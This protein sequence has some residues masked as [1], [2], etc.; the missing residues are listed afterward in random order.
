M[1]RVEGFGSGSFRDGIQGVAVEEMGLDKTAYS[2]MLDTSML[3]L[4][5]D[6]RSK[7]VYVKDLTYADELLEVVYTIKY[8]FEKELTM[9]SIATALDEYMIEEDI[10]PFKMED[11]DD[12][13]SDEY[14]MSLVN[15]MEFEE[16]EEMDI[17]DII[18]AI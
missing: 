16:T 15:S 10:E 17:Y 9:Q 3:A 6:K 14:F 7:T 8:D 13:M 12:T 2:K 11:R 1:L 4:Y 5:L 18:E